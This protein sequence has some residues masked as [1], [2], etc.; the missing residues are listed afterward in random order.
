[1]VRV[2]REEWRAQSV[3]GRA[4]PAGATV[5]VVRAEGTRVVVEPL[6]ES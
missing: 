6:E 4:I 1:M 5:R 3:D 2:D